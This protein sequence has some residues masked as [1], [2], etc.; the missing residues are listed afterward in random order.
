MKLFLDT[1]DVNEIRKYAPLLSGVTT[2]PSL[3]MKSGRDFREVVNEI[4][5][6]VDGPI[7]AEAVSMDAEGMFKEAKE[8]SSWHKNIVVKIPMTLEGLKAVTMCKAAGIKTN[9]TLVFSSPQ[10]LLAAEAGATYVS[11]F[12]G[13]LDD[14]GQDG[15]ALIEEIMQIYGNYSYD[16]EVIAASL[17]NPLHVIDSAMAGAD[18]ATIPPKL[19]A[20]MFNHP[21]TDLGVKQF[22]DDWKQAKK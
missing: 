5:T 16:T 2:N 14:I 21:L 11:P 8:L 13:R 3:I 17:R 10:A 20:Q 1:A 22:L 7:S 6:I 4:C 19:M 15:I 18:I 12:V 9:V